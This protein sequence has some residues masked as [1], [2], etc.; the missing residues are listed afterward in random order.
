MCPCCSGFL[1]G[2][3]RLLGDTLPPAGIDLAIRPEFSAQ[4]N[5]SQ[6]QE[7]VYLRHL[8]RRKRAS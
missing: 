7:I 6:R 8:G 2:A 3:C 4:V 5:G 1:R